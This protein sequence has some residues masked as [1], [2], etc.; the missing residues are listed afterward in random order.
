MNKQQQAIKE[1]EAMK[2]MSELKALSNYSLEHPLT[3]K[4][5]RRIMEL[6]KKIFGLK[7]P[8]MT[9]YKVKCKIRMHDEVLPLMQEIEAEDFANAVE[10][11]V[12]N[13]V[14]TMGI[15][16]WDVSEFEMII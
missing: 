1:F 6:K 2:D 8:K 5:F 12:N 9:K 16:P 7:K 10:K 4:Q 13:I 15:S 3:D 11:I 14:D